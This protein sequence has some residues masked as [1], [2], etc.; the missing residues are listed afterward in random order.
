MLAAD[1]PLVTAPAVEPPFTPKN[2]GTRFVLVPPE[3]WPGESPAGWAAKIT[4]STK[5]FVEVK[6]KDDKGK[7]YTQRFTFE[8]VAQW[9]PLS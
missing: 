5:T 3:I 6:L 7:Q 8:Q 1:D 9:K 4:K 2:V